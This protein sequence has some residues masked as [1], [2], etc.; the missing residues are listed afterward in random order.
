MNA[1][2]CKA[3]RRLARQLSVG[4]PER[5]LLGKPRKVKRTRKGKT[6]EYEAQ[7]AVNNPRSMRGTYHMLKKFIRMGVSI[8]TLEQQ[9]RPKEAEMADGAAA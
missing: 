2:K 3:V 4:L 6:F 9:M 7:Q 5:Q 1:K 8:A